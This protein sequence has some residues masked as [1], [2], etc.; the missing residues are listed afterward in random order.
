MIELSSTTDLVQL[1]VSTNLT[2]S[3]W[4]LEN[5]YKTRLAG[6][7]KLVELS[8]PYKFRSRFHPNILAYSLT[9]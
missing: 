1:V 7:G 9:V 5:K 6:L 2:I 4:S 8:S 3:Q